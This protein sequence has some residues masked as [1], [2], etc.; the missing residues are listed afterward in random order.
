LDLPQ[1][2]I[3][4]SKYFFESTVSVVTVKYVDGFKRRVE[5][6]MEMLK[7]LLYSMSIL[8]AGLNKPK[9]V[10]LKETFFREDFV[11]GNLKFQ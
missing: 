4:V 9:L 1:K 5:L 10:Y 7:D 6:G 2:Y 8:I 11:S 3:N